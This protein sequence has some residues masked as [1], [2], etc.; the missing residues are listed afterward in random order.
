VTVQF[1]HLE[2]QT[3]EQTDRHDNANSRISQFSDRAFVCNAEMSAPKYSQYGILNEMQTS[4]CTISCIVVCSVHR[5]MSSSVF[6]DNCTCIKSTV[7][8]LSSLQQVAAHHTC[9]L[10]GVSVVITWTLSNGPLYEKWT[11]V[12]QCLLSVWI[13]DSGM[14]HHAGW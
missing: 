3:D 14:W 6:R 5:V 2:R 10:Q 11:L 7:C 12:S 1:F 8:M 13:V 9:H 4:G